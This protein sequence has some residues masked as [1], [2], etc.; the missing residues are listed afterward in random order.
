MICQGSFMVSH[1]FWLY[2]WC[3]LRTPKRYS[4]HLYLGPTIPLGL[5]GRDDDDD[6]Q[7][8]VII[9][10]FAPTP[11][12][13]RIISLTPIVPLRSNCFTSSYFTQCLASLLLNPQVAWLLLQYSPATVIISPALGDTA[14]FKKMDIYFERIFWILKKWIIFF[15]IN[16]LDF[17]KMKIYFEWIF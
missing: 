9:H 14:T 5:A 10:P 3:S 11:Y 15:W 2:F 1:G 7:V 16:D 8:E 13:H 12:K 4:L 6:V 17:E